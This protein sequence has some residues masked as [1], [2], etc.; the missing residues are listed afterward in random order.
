MNQSDRIE[1]K[2]DQLLE[3]F[4]KRKKEK[5]DF[6]ALAEQAWNKYKNRKPKK[7]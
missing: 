2:L 1:K 7:P 4:Q 6:D 3:I 5:L